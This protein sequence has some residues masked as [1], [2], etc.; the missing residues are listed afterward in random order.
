MKKINFRFYPVTP[1]RYAIIGA[2][3]MNWLLAIYYDDIFPH[4]TGLYSLVHS[5]VFILL[6]ILYQFPYPLNLFRRRYYFS[7]VRDMEYANQPIL[8]E[9]KPPL[10]KKPVFIELEK[11]LFLIKE[12][13]KRDNNS[14]MGFC[15]AISRRQAMHK[16]SNLYITPVNP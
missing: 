1:F 13:F 6:F 12:T 11:D 9:K 10:S 2:Y 4:P 14:C 3:S 8:L 7:L 5:A 16:I 15:R